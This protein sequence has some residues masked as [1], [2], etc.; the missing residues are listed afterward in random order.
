MILKP[1]TGTYAQPCKAKTE[2]FPSVMIERVTIRVEKTPFNLKLKKALL[3]RIKKVTFNLRLK[4]ALQIRIEEMPF[5]L[6]QR[7]RI[8]IMP[9]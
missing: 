4:K 5:N 9:F 2:K 8:E 7:F 6:I 3:P 1:S